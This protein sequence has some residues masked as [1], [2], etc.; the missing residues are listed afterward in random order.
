MRAYAHNC[1]ATELCPVLALPLDSCVILNV[2]PNP[3]E[4]EAFTLG[5]MLAFLDGGISF[6]SLPV[7]IQ[8]GLFALVGKKKT[9]FVSC[10]PILCHIC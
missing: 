1:S 7:D 9:Q 4:S 8:S 5:C 6:L 3:S 10:C 2:S